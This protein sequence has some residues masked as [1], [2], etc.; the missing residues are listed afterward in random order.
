MKKIDYCSNHEDVV[1]AEI[2][3]RCGKHICYNCVV[4]MFGKTFCSNE[5]LLIDLIRR[6]IRDCGRF[7]IAFIKLFLGS[8]K[9]LRTF[10]R[11]AWIETIL[12]LSLVV[13]FYF[14]YQ[15]TGK[16][17]KLT[18]QI[19]NQ[20]LLSET[21]DTTRI[22]P[23][24]I[25][26]PAKGGMVHSNTIDIHGEVETNR[27]VSLSLNGQLTH[28]VLPKAGKFEFPDVRLHRGQNHLVVR[29]IGEN[30]EISTLEIMDVD[31]GPPT[32]PFL[33]RDFSRGSIH[34]NEIAF[35]F[36]G[37]STNNVAHEILDILKDKGVKSTFFL[38][39]EFIRR[40]PE[41]VRRIVVEDHEVGNHTW[42]HPHLTTFAKNRKQQTL[43]EITPEKILE[44]LSKTASLFQLVTGKKMSPIWRAPYGEFNK[45]ILKWAAEAGYKHVGWTVGK[46]WEETMDTM[47]WVA[48]RN[49][50]AYHSADEIRDKILEYSGKGENGANGAVILMHLGTHRSDDLPHKK[51]PE[52]IDGLRE[53]AYQIVKISEMM[54][55]D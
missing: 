22:P 1:A 2:C 17:N 44:E 20:F 19:N 25:R 37:G 21:V 30:G 43:L 11:R 3:E 16:L 24:K 46:G 49:S 54:A 41:T 6:M 34:R 42:S 12:V 53:K 5:C 52:I 55:A 45:E 48:D 9:R 28:V 26:Q 29:A 23:P 32:L 13:A 35:T 4:K 47:D 27:I 8:F 31:Y 36:D 15:L 7:V 50:K 38:T 14:I 33:V 51:L 10:T 39:G 18:D 40:Y